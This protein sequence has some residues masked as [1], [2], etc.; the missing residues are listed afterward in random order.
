MNKL[1]NQHREIAVSTIIIRSPLRANPPPSPNRSTRPTHSCGY[2]MWKLKRKT[3]QEIYTHSE[4]KIF[5][6][7]KCETARPS[8]SARR[9]DH[10][11]V[12]YAGISC[13]GIL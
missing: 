3:A 12:M 11:L 1:A 6:G 4:G 7:C 13:A 9:L 8:Q 10:I 2:E 5:V